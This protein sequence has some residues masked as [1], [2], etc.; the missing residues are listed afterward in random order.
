[1]KKSFFKQ[2]IALIAILSLFLLLLAVAMMIFEAKGMDT[3]RMMMAISALQNIGIFIIPAI[4]VAQIFNPGKAMQVMHL[5]KAPQFKHFILTLLLMFVAVPMMNAIITWNASWQLPE[6]LSWMREQE[7]NA[8]ETTAQMMA[9]TSY[10]ELAVIILVVCVLTGI[11]EEFF[12]RGSLQRLM[13]ESGLNVHIAVWGVAF[14]FSA[15]HMQVFGFVPRMLLGAIF[16]YVMLWSGNLWLPVIA[17]A[18]NNTLAVFTMTSPAFSSNLWFAGYSPATL[19][20]SVVATMAVVALFYRSR[21][22]A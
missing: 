5:N 21:V 14:I 12:F 7:N 3:W 8:M 19:M 6:A 1:M 17:H 13:Q 22:R 18:I 9:Y 10:I 16:G 11:G 20:V 2:F 15:V 4:I